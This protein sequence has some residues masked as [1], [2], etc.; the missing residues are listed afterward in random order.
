MSPLQNTHL[1]L[2]N[3]GTVEY[4]EVIEQ[5]YEATKAW[6]VLVYASVVRNVGLKFTQCAD[7]IDAQK[8]H[9]S[10]ILAVHG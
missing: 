7:Q 1:F 9:A 10:G 4:Y 5:Y 8:R 3:F 2:C 6:M